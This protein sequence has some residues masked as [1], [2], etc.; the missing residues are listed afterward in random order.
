MCVCVCVCVC[1]CEVSFS[2]VGRCSKVQQ[3]RLLEVK[4]SERADGRV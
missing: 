1:V 3:G 2:Q 4:K